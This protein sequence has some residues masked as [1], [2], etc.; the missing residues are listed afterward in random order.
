MALARQALGF[1]E[2]KL[3]KAFNIAGP[4]GVTLEPTV[5]PV[6]IVDDTR[7]PGHAFYQGRSWAVPQAALS[8]AGDFYV[9]PV[10]FLDDCLVET[11]YVFGQLPANQVLSL[12]LVTPDQWQNAPPGGV[13]SLGGQGAS[14]RDRNDRPGGSA[15]VTDVPP[16]E[17]TTGWVAP[18]GG[19]VGPVVGNTLINLP[20]GYVPVPA[21]FPI[22]VFVPRGGALCWE[23]A[24]TQ[25]VPLAVGMWGRV[26]G[27]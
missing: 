11:V 27:P 8:S 2:E 15:A 25:A 19:T 16:I 17:S 5:T 1:V 26:W 24:D 22:Q 12:F 13:V 7:A 20:G 10:H 14:W 9:W 6:I 18:S 4:I 3:R 23:L 21:I